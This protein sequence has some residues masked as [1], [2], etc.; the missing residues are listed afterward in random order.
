MAEKDLASRLLFVHRALLSGS[1]TA[2]RDLHLLCLDPLVARLRRQAPHLP[3]DTWED[4]AH[5]AILTFIL[6][7]EKYDSGKS[8][9]LGYLTVIAE[10]RMIDAIRRES[11]YLRANIRETDLH[12]ENSVANEDETANTPLEAVAERDGNT[13]MRNRQSQF[14]QESQLLQSDITDLLCELLP[15]RRDQRVLALVMQGR[16]ATAEYSAA[17]GL[18]YLPPDEQPREVKRHRD[19]IMKRVGRARRQWEKLLR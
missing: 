1:P 19:R 17:L 16:N 11:R 8:G 7:P 9:I 6:N 10:R 5:D 2:S 15:D 12:S 3:R 18:E 4:A 13:L 14:L